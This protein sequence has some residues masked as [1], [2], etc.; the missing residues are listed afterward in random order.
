MSKEKRNPHLEKIVIGPSMVLL[1]M[2]MGGHYME[3]LKIKKQS[4][5]YTYPNIARNIWN[6][7]AYRGFYL[8]FYPWGMMQMTKGLPVL[9]V[10]S[11]TFNWFNNY[12]NLSQNSKI[13]YSGVLGGMVQG[14]FITPTQRIKTIIMTHPD[15]KNLSHISILKDTYRSGGLVTFFL[16]LR[17]L[18]LRRGLDWGIRMYGIKATEDKLKSLQDIKT[19]S[20]SQKLLCSF[21]GGAFSTITTPI[22]TCISESQKF[23]NKDKGPIKIC[24][25]I[26]QKYGLRGFTRGWVMRVFHAGYHTVW[27]YGVGNLLFSMMRE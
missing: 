23:A 1:E 8:G 26:Y 17:P 21:I 4:S 24:Q 6:K 7:H 15:N 11:E 2:V 18:V 16:G 3:T 12:T 25:E 14:A 20:N 22:D 27:I 9:F 19:L 13:L 10:Q 5:Y